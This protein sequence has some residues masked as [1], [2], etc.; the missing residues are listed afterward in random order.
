MEALSTFGFNSFREI[1]EFVL[2]DGS[3]DWSAI[4]DMFTAFAGCGRDKMERSIMWIR[5]RPTKVSEE[6]NAIRA[7]IIYFTAA[8]ADFISLRSGIT[9]VLDTRS[10]NMDEKI[11]NEAKLQ[12][13]HQSIPLRPQKIYII[14]AGYFKRLL[15]NAAISIASLFTKEKIL[16]RIRFAE[17][18]EVNNDVEDLSM[19]QC[20]GGSCEIVSN[21]QLVE[22]VKSRI[23]NF[24]ILPDEL[25]TL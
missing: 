13:F 15:I 22:W 23:Q 12:K 17:L 3:G 8:H 25:D 19:P 20:A 16:E 2:E 11:G 10:S 1:W 24:P 6:G 7:S 9:F 5:T 14:G 21:K 4:E 18:E